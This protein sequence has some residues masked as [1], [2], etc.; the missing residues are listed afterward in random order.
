[1]SGIAIVGAGQ[2]GLAVAEAL[3]AG[4]YTGA[5][6]LFGD[7]ARGPYHRPPL[8]KGY[9]LG[10][11]EEA[12]LVMRA[13]ALL[14]KRDIALAAGVG[15][16]AIDRVARCVC[17]TDGRRIAYDGLALCTGSRPRP[18]A[19]PGAELSGVRTLRT[20]EDSAAI[21]AALSR[22][23]RVVVIGGGFIGLEVAAA[24][25]KSG[26]AVIVLEAADRLMPRVVSSLIS[27]FY[28]GLH[29]A[30]GAQVELNAAVT[31]LTAEADR[32]AAVETADGRTFL[33]DLV[34]VGI[35]ILPNAELAAVAGLAV[36]GGIVVDACSRT[37]DPRIVA[38]G[39]CT[40]RRMA[41]GTLR[42][43]E[44]VQNAVEQG[45]S[46]AATL[47]GHE[48]AF[49]AAPWFWSDQYDV[50]LQMAGLA[51]GHDR[52]VVRGDVA[53]RRFSAFYFAGD[54]LIA[55]DSVNRAEDHLAVR[56]LLDRGVS[57]TM[58]QAADVT[59]GL[60]TLLA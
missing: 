36:D 24:A 52:V 27:E 6:T 15:V 54:R 28:R 39:D 53:S 16:A 43:L 18:L 50:K 58:E 34:I 10:A 32:V 45:K 5:V 17:L 1:M 31:R 51:H 48:R 20:A 33:A 47:L 21:A 29:A 19:L 38:A 41:D 46:A 12:Q 40:V 14:A 3:R 4:G 23:H 25:R 8:S 49:D 22:A 35:G 37:S 56:K 57:P 44:S 2:A 26:K 9:L 60:S 42:R 30:N 11:I 7:E 55:A 13:P 59:F